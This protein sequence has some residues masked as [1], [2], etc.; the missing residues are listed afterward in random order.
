MRPLTRPHKLR[1]G[2]KVA[3]ISLSWGGPATFPKRYAAGKRQ[4]E[5]TFGVTVVETAHALKDEDWLYANPEAR[6]D[7]LMHA[8]ADPSIRAI[9]A[10]IGGDDSIRTL[11][12][13]DLDIIRAHPKIFLGFSDP[14]I[15]HLA[16][17]KAGLISFY[18]PTIMTGFAENGGMHRYAVESLRRTLFSAENAPY[19]LAPNADGWTV[20][21]LD[22][23][24]P[25][26]Q[27]QKRTLNPSTGW[28]WLQGSGVRRG[29]LIGGCFEVFDF[30]RGTDYWPDDSM[31]EDAIL[32]LETS[33]DMPAPSSL[34]YVLRSYAAMG[35]LSKLAGI[36][37]ARPGGQMAQEKFKE[38]D[39][40][41]TTVVSG[42]MGLDSLPIISH[43]DFGHTDPVC[44]LPYGVLVEID[45][46]A[47]KILFLES[48][49]SDL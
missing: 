34:M 8:F 25:S 30:L 45:C 14:T 26:Y 11:P 19:L 24:N 17:L 46:D 47:Q 38:Y 5:E 42:E 16:C 13:I 2:D 15:A 22:W 4:L 23:G 20:E 12:F 33:E 1:P 49:V 43:M 29:R 31:W 18:G 10:T 40:V 9:V 44:V 28:R 21:M 32:F 35:I 6:A 36:L 39:D 48:G 27:S 7:D 3:A 37:F 41:L